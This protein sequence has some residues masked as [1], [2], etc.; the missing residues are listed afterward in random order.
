MV[1]KIKDKSIN[2]SFFFVQDK[3]DI[4][5]KIFYYLLIFI[6]IILVFII[7][8]KYLKDYKKLNEK[9]NIELNLLNN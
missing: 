6:L 9:K 2:S 1:I 8:I 7:I 3:N 5:I 4:N